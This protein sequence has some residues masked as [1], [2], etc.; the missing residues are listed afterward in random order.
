MYSLF[1]ILVIFELLWDFSDCLFLSLSFLFTLV[2]SMAPK[3]KSAPSQNPSRSRASSSSSNPIPSHIR[4]HDENARK[5]FSKNFSQRGVHLEH[6]VILADFADID[7][8]DVI[9]SRGWESLCDVPVTCPSMLIQEFY[10]NMHGFDYL[11]SLFS[12]HI[13]GTH[14]VVKPQLVAN[15]LHVSRVE[16]PDYPRCERLRTVSKNE[17]ISAFCKRPSNWGDCQFTPCKAFAKGPRFINMVTTFI[18]HPLSHYNSITE[19][20]ARFCC[21]FLSTSL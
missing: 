7:L 6:R 5:D 18:L 20:R 15:V 2:M 11:V 21:L 1:N 8:P 3:R 14:I 16:H 9:H 13:R 10:S 12:T 4:F 17:M 19:P